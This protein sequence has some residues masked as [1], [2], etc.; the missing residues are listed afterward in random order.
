M[1]PNPPD[2]IDYDTFMAGDLQSRIR[3]FNEVSAENRAALISTHIRR[4]IAANKQRLS[5]E[6]MGMTD[7]WLRF[8]TPGAYSAEKPEDARTQ[9][10]DL[11]T[12]TAALFSREDM[13]EAMTIYARHIPPT[14]QAE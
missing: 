9:L 12:R 1:T 14:E 5:A 2:S 13:G 3:T 8:V 4:W 11:E 7:L 10:K 6:Q